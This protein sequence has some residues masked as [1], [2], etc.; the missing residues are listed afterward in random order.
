[1]PFQI[2]PGV[3]VTEKDLTN[4]V[5]A[6]ATTVGGI[7]GYFQWGPCE[8]RVLVD[9]EDNLVS[10]FGKPDNNTAEYFWTAAN[11]LGYTNALQVVRAI[12]STAG[13]AM[14]PGT[15]LRGDDYTVGGPAK[16]LIKNEDD[17]YLNHVAGGTNPGVLSTGLSGA[18][19]IWWAAKYPGALGNSLKVSVSD[20]PQIQITSNASDGITATVDTRYLHIGSS[21]TGGMSASNGSGASTDH[22][23]GEVAVGDHILLGGADRT[24]IVTGFSGGALVGVTGEG[25]TANHK[26]EEA[27][28]TH[29]LLDKTISSIDA[30]DGCTATV[31]WA[32]NGN[33]SRFPET[34][35][36]AEKFGAYNDEVQI[37]VIDEGGL[38]SGAKGTVLESFIASKAQDAKKF[39]GT[40]NYYV[41]VINETS[42]YIWW[43]DHPDTLD[44]LQGVSGGAA[45]REWG[46]TFVNIEGGTAAGD[47]PNSGMTF[48]SLVRNFYA[49]LTGGSDGDAFTKTGLYTNGYD[50]FQDAE[51]VD[52]SLLLGGPV[53]ETVGGQLIDL[54]DARKDCVAFLSP[55]REDVVNIANATTAQQN[56]VDYYNNTLNKSSSYGVFDSGWK[57]Q[58]DR[59][60]D[61]FRYIPLNGDIAGL[62]ARTENTNDAWWSPAGFNRGQIRN[63][64]KLAYNPR[65]AHR[66]NLYKNNLNPVVSFP[67]EGT[68][69]F[70]DKTMQRKP[71]AFDRIN[72]RRLF[73]VLEKAI[74]TAAKYQL[75]EFNDEFT[76]SNFVNMVTPFLRDVQGRRGIFDFRVVCDES[77]NTG[78]VI[79]RNEFVADIFIKPARSIN[80]IQL[81]FVAVRTGVDFEEIAGA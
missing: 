77:N 20:K 55:R 51:T 50:Q 19:Q 38:F 69:L 32:Y 42:K 40:G 30:C 62:C 9:S 74:A 60:N 45:A 2:S 13:S 76:R 31:N 63:I 67:G 66:D 64:V 75:F 41:N 23:R 54:V 46:D 6:V 52:V 14:A 17:Y 70:G 44:T 24:Y 68:V 3:N 21:M 28:Y 34:S 16:K 25:T 15:G 78:E 49:G 80:F 57:Y 18:D 47:T 33:F 5:P 37:A 39:D 48:G 35:T 59:Y 27:S 58:Y 43:G 81:N 26:L 56:A 73:I 29:I 61:M 71:S 8:E 79:D 53:E 12:P 22:I 72:V 7:A 1:M 11:F 4:I 36:D 65:K 10:L